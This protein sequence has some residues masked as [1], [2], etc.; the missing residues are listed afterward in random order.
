MTNTP[1]DDAT[2]DSAYNDV[3]GDIKGELGTTT[4][5]ALWGIAAAIHELAQVVSKLHTKEEG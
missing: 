4:D 5:A 3:I 2:Y 1:I